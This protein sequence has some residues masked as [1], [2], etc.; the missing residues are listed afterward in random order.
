MNVGIL[1]LSIHGNYGGTLQNY[2][3]N[4]VLHQ[5]GVKSETIDYK[6]QKHQRLKIKAFRLLRRLGGASYY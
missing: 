1:T 6:N 3:L 2:A 4:T 5:H